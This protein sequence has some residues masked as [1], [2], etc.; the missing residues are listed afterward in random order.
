MIY[1]ERIATVSVMQ[2]CERR[3]YC[4]QPL[5]EFFLRYYFLRKRLPS[6]YRSLERLG[7]NFPSVLAN[8]GYV[9][10]SRS[11]NF[12]L[13]NTISEIGGLKL[14]TPETTGKA[15]PAPKSKRKNPTRQELESMMTEKN[16]KRKQCAHK[17]C[18]K[19]VGLIYFVCKY[20]LKKY[21]SE[22]QNPLVHSKK[23]EEF[24]DLDLK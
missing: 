5:K 11:Q 17:G 18:K 21:C 2:H 12:D 3:Q 9:P 4:L 24:Y 13:E 22:H 23:C 14:D 16:R 6:S 7:S 20:C 15:K 1:Y 8:F 19:K 10:N